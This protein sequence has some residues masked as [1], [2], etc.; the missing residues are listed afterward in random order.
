MGLLQTEADELERP[1]AMFSLRGSC[2]PSMLG[3]IFMLG[4]ILRY[5]RSNKDPQLAPCFQLL[6][7]ML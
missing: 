5:F 7:G 6:V 4:L 2:C 1:M 3:L